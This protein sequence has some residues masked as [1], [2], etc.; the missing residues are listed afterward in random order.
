MGIYS[1]NGEKKSSKKDCSDGIVPPEP[2]TVDTQ[3][4][5]CS[6][7][8]VIVNSSPPRILRVNDLFF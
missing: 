7:D 2:T 5:Y 4:I 8:V 3:K 6:V 1:L